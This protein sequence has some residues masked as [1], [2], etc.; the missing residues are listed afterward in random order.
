M[1]N[2][3]T[4]YRFE[5][6]KIFGRKITLVVLLIMTAAMAA[7]N[8]TEYVAVKKASECN[9]EEL[10]GR[11]LDDSLF[12]EMRLGIKPNIMTDSLG[13]EE[14]ENVEYIDNAY[15]NLFHYLLNVSGNTT[16]AYNISEAQLNK[17]FNEIIDHAYDDFKLSDEEISYWE[18]K[19][20]D[21]ITPPVY[22]KSAGWSNG[23]VNLYM[24]N[25]FI[26][27]T[28]GAILSGVFADEYSLRTDAIVFASA[29]GKKRLSCVK[30]LAGCTVGLIVSA[31]MIF[32]YTILEFI[33]YGPL[34]PEAS[35]QLTY[36]P[37]VLDMPAKKACLICMGILL[38]IG[39]FYS[40][41]TMFLSQLFQNATVPIAILAVLLICSMLN[42]PNSYRLIA[43]IAS[44]LPATFPG[45]W[46]F[47]DYRLL[48]I[49]GLRFNILQVLP[50]LYT[51]LIMVFAVCTYGSYERTQIKGR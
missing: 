26:L 38:I 47:T 23:I 34:D 48:N 10:V 49:F 4:L 15:R 43:Q 25:F 3:G 42:P 51:M 32:G 1:N 39:L 36:G 40:I 6:K 27:I 50:V 5:L 44:Y 41:L 33:L 24:S 7:V 2:F 9:D 8:I 12:D 46:T 16:R 30:M 29:N 17:T 13:N 14:I 37:T 35:I 18:A 19:R 21:I 11:Q 28:I 45:S 22:D 20:A 31:F